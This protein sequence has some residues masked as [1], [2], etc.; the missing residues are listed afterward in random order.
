MNKKLLIILVL[1]PLLRITAIAQVPNP[2]FE[3]LLS[4]GYPANWGNVYIFSAWIDSNGVSHGDSIL[5]D[6]WFYQSTND[7]HSGQYALELRNAYNVTQNYAIGGAAG[8]DEDTLFTAWG[9]T[10]QV[11]VYGV[12]LDFK[13]YYKYFPVNGDTAYAFVSVTDSSGAIIGNAETFITGNTSAYTYSS[14]PITYIPGSTPAFMSIQFHTSQPGGQTSYGTRLLID[15][16]E[17]TSSTTVGEKEPSN[18]NRLTIYPNPA[19]E[20]ISMNVDGFRAEKIVIYDLQG[21][22][23]KQDNNNLTEIQISDLPRGAYFLEVS[24]ENKI[25]KKLFIRN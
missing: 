21:K 15:D 6:G 1:I 16:V 2:G 5:F 11:P 9:I 17:I 24:G 14:T 20:K 22:I 23:V 13:F 7:A 25:A 3:T 10:E 18:K 4:N 19:S 12:P 8:A